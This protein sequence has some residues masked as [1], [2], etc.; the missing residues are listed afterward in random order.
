M[1][2]NRSANCAIIAHSLRDFYFNFSCNM[3][4]QACITGARTILVAESRYRTLRMNIV[5]ALVVAFGIV[6]AV[7]YLYR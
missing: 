3:R 1:G 4:E 7:I 5:I 6:M 2:G